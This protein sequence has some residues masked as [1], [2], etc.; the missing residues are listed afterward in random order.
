MES[1]RARPLHLPSLRFLAV[2]RALKRSVTGGPTPRWYWLHFGPSISWL[3]WNGD[4]KQNDKDSLIDTFLQKY[5]YSEAFKYFITLSIAQTH[6]ILFLFSSVKGKWLQVGHSHC[7][8]K[9]FIFNRFFPICVS[10][11]GINISRFPLASSFNCLNR[12]VCHSDDHFCLGQY[13]LLHLVLYLLLLI[14]F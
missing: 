1:H 7:G 13:H 5:K 9:A 2:C 4:R 12:S 6:N 14:L 11:T 3:S 8:C 10:I